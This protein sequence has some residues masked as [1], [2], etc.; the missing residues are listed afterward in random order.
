MSVHYTEEDIKRI[1]QEIQAGFDV[2]VH[3]KKRKIIAVPKSELIFESK[4][5]EKAYRREFRQIKRHREDYI[6]IEDVESYRKWNLMW[7]FTQ[8]V[9]DERFQRR[10]QRAL[11]GKKPFRSFK[12]VLLW[13][14]EI[15]Q[16]WFEFKDEFYFNHVKR[17][18][19][20]INEEEAE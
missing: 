16:K 7:D 1:A 4:E 5:L 6:L 8:T 13:R 18:I 10:L 19:D 20:R 14:P 3:K 12:D 11:E 9:L 17:F 2:Y 15:R